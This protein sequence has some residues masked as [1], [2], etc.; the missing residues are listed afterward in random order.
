MAG[1]EVYVPP[2]GTIEYLHW[3]LFLSHDSFLGRLLYLVPHADPV[4]RRRIRS[5][6]PWLVDAWEAWMAADGGKFELP[7]G[8]KGRADDAP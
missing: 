1:S 3:R 5:Q 7:P 6:W 2:R 8:V 4:N